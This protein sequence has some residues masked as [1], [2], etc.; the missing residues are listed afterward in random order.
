MVAAK[1]HTC[2]VF[3]SL[4]VFFLLISLQRHSVGE[5][6]LSASGNVRK[7]FVRWVV[8]GD[9]IVLGNNEHVRYVGM[10]TPER[11]EPFYKEARRRNI[12]L[13]KGKTITLVVCAE[14]PKDKYG[15]TLGWVWADAVPV[16]EVLLKEGLA[17]T[18]MI[19]PCGLKKKKDYAR[20][21][22]E[23]KSRRIGIWSLRR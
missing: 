6:S 2:R 21:E 7:G 23:A 4:L 22:S 1:A 11:G 5:D 13:V 12:E 17:K 18:L 3:F 16:N 14:Q 19:P 20:L 9:T 10:D 8:D 15:R